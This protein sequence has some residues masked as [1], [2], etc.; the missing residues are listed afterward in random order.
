MAYE[1][2]KQ[3]RSHLEGWTP[4]SQ[5]TTQQYLQAFR[6]MAARN[7]APESIAQT[8]K[9]FYL[10]RASLIY[11]ASRQIKLILKQ[12]SHAQKARDDSSWLKLIPK[13]QRQ[14][15]I[16]AKYPRDTA[17]QHINQGTK[18]ISTKQDKQPRSNAK[19]K[20]LGSL[21]HDWRQQIWE[22]TPVGWK[23]RSALSVLSATGCRPSELEAGVKVEW[24][25]HQLLFS[26]RGTKTHNGQYGQALRTLTLNPNAS[27]ETLFLFEQCKKA[28][29]GNFV[30]K[31]KN[32]KAFSEAVRRKSKKIWPHQKY[33]VSPYSYRHQFAADIKKYSTPSDIAKAL[34]HCVERTQQSYGHSNQ[35]KR[36]QGKL[37]HV[38]ATRK[39]KQ[40]KAT[41]P[42][43][44][45]NNKQ[46]P[47]L[48]RHPEKP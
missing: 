25:D 23:Y 39:V 22:S 35:A 46:A 13:L 28:D 14:L 7:E 41:P 27:Q 10:Y 34:G 15:K 4:P 47:H 33:T 26:V 11:V 5:Q 1:I 30:V 37:V 20:G 40:N 43:P 45:D 3:A 38:E 8:K 24:K 9:S 31:I 42:Q 32:A 29:K 6:R 36:G 17:R 48:N 12:I 18:T 21:P 2:I 16:L 44:S 19:R